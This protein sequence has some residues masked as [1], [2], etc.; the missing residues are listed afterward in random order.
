LLFFLCELERLHNIGIGNG[1]C[2]HAV[3]LSS[4]R[5]GI[6]DLVLGRTGGVEIIDNPGDELSK[7]FKGI[8]GRVGSELPCGKRVC[9]TGHSIIGVGQFCG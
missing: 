3:D 2:P 4:E 1:F 7:S 5:F 9:D 8:F 6:V